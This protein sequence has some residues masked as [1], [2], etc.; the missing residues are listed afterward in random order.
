[1]VSDRNAG[2][3]QAYLA[4]V[5]M[6]R[7]H[8]FEI[9]EQAWFPKRLRNAVLDILQHV[10]GLANY[11]E[12]IAPLLQSALDRTGCKQVVDLCSGAGG[13]WLQLL[14]LLERRSQPARVRVCLSDK[15]PNLKAFRKVDQLSGHRIGF[16]PAAIDAVD[17]PASLSGFRTLF[18]SFHHF[19]PADARR[20]L[21]DA[22]KRKEG[23]AIFEVPRRTVASVLSVSLVPLAGLFVLPFAHAFSVPVFVFTYLIPVVPFVL[24]FDGVV[25][26]LRAY[27]PAELQRIADSVALDDY[28]WTVGV[29]KNEL[30]ALPVTYLL[31]HPSTNTAPPAVAHDQW[32]NTS[33]ME[34]PALGT[35]AT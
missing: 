15:F 22:A 20:I 2:K 27:T 13:P 4:L 12:T 14:K 33:A 11:Y 5:E 7:I 18:N 30:S 31:G 26:C 28:K 32:R 3:G 23:I 8:L 21:V 1:V 10:L 9:H 25:S 17:V 24:F 16:C 6:K 34:W 29:V 19:P 35:A